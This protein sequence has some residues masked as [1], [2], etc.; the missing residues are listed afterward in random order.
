LCLWPHTSVDLERAFDDARRAVQTPQRVASI[1]KDHI[2]S[3]PVVARRHYITTGN[4]RHFEVRYCSIG[5]LPGLVT[6]QDDQADGVIVVPL[7]ETGPERNV[8]L[9]F[10]KQQE[11][12]ARLNWLVAVPQPLSHLT[13]LVQEVQRW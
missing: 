12:A 9:E 13:G 6:A 1:I 4:L 7:C 10:A 3:R 2:E 11:V 5:E 8:A